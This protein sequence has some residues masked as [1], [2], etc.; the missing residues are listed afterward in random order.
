MI[1]STRLVQL[2]FCIR[3]PISLNDGVLGLYKYYKTV[4]GSAAVEFTNTLHKETCQCRKHQYLFGLLNYR[5]IIEFVFFACLY[6]RWSPEHNIG[7]VVYS[8]P[9]RLII[10]NTVTDTNNETE[11]ENC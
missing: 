3:I 1:R 5:K 11:K 4:Y 6:I 7:Y 2:V 9:A 10:L 8:T